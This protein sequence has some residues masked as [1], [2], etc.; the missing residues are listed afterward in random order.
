VPEGAFIYCRD[1]RLVERANEL[2]DHP[3]RRGWSDQ[4]IFAEVMDEIAGEW[5]GVDGHKAMG[6]EPYCHA[7]Y[8]QYHAP[9]DRLF[10]TTK[11]RTH[12]S[13]LNKQKRRE[14]IRKA[15]AGTQ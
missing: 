9:A 15:R 1:P 6:F 8:C 13:W 5:P 11:G 2:Y 7:I 12:G 10:V 14:A 3:R 4:A